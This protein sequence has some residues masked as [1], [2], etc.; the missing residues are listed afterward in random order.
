MHVACNAFVDPA[1]G[2]ESTRIS[3][4]GEAVLGQKANGSQ[5]CEFLSVGRAEVGA[6]SVACVASRSLLPVVQKKYLGVEV[7]RVSQLRQSEEG[8]GQV[9]REEGAEQGEPR[10]KEKAD[11]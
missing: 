7:L 10:K 2:E 8:V 1:P 9:E 4:T 11:L 6:G 5:V 3:C